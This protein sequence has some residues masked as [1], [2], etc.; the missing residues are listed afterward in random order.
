S[1]D[2]VWKFLQEMYDPN[3]DRSKPETW[4]KNLCHCQK[5]R[6]TVPKINKIERTH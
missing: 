6:K 4:R 1:V 5:P 2:E 3:I